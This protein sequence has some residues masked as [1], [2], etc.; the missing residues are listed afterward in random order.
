M[1]KYRILAI[2]LI[3]LMFSQITFAQ[4]VDIWAEAPENT[5]SQGVALGSVN[6]QNSK[7][8]IKNFKNFTTFINLLTPPESP[9]DIKALY[10]SNSKFA[11]PILTIE[12]EFP[13]DTIKNSPQLREKITKQI[14]IGLYFNILKN[15]KLADLQKEEFSLEKEKFDLVKQTVEIPAIAEATEKYTAAQSELFEYEKAKK[16]CI[17]QFLVFTQLKNQPFFDKTFDDFEIDPSIKTFINDA[18]QQTDLNPTQQE[19]L[20]KMRYDYLK[21]KNLK[22]RITKQEK[23]PLPEELYKELE[24]KQEIIELKKQLATAKLTCIVEYLGFCDA[25]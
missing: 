20:L 13:V 16:L 21:Y 1:K 14:I 18:S 4:C 3:L 9:N 5:L 7:L 8:F 23:Q 11:P 22:E 6:S 24:F 12:G 10:Y 17:N 2:I 25:K 15:Q 19:I